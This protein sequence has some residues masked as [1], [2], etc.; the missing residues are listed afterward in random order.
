VNR[1]TPVAPLGQPQLNVPETKSHPLS[2][3][4]SRGRPLQPRFPK[5]LQREA[6]AASLQPRFAKEP[7]RRRAA[8]DILTAKQPSASN[9]IRLE[10][11][12]VK[13]GERARALAGTSAPSISSAGFHAFQILARLIRWS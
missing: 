12:R 1:G 7:H 6:P 11:E 3:P 4:S 13:E 2:P 10:I 9:V 8:D 5:E